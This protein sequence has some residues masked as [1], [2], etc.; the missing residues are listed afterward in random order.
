M[1]SFVSLYERIPKAGNSFSY[2]TILKFCEV[3]FRFGI[4]KSSLSLSF[5]LKNIRVYLIYTVIFRAKYAYQHIIHYVEQLTTTV[6]CTK[7][8]FI[9]I[10]HLW[11]EQHGFPM[12]KMLLF[13]NQLLQI[14]SNAGVCKIVAIQLA[15]LKLMQLLIEFLL[16]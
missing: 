2:V 13:M 3:N 9:T 5:S 12:K 4:S 11:I 6:K 7:L 10:L 8:F 16:K 1:S 14:I 15:A